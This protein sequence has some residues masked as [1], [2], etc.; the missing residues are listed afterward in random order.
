MTPETIGGYNYEY[1]AMIAQYTGWTYH[2]TFG[3]WADLETKLANHEIDL[4][5]DVGKTTERLSRYNF[6]DYPNISSQMY[7]VTRDNDTRYYYDDFSA[8]NGMKIGG[9]IS[10]FREGLLSKKATNNSFQ[11]TYQCYSSDDTALAALDRG[12]ID[13]VTLINTAKSQDYRI[14]SEWEPNP[15]YF[16]VS[17]TKSEILDELNRSLNAIQ[18]SDPSLQSR[19]YEKYFEDSSKGRNV[20]L[21][22]DEAN[23]LAKK[24]SVTIAVTSGEKPIAYEKDGVLQGI[25]PDYFSLLQTKMPLKFN[26]KVYGTFQEMFTLFMA[27]KSELCAQVPDDFSYGVTL[28]ARLANPYM[29]LTYGFVSKPDL[30]GNAKKIAYRVGKKYLK[31]RLEKLGYEAISYV[32][33]E[34]CISAVI[35]GEVDAAAMGTL[36]YEQV[37]YHAKYRSLSYFTKPELDYSVCIGVT[38][39]EDPLL[40]SALQKAV[41]AIPASALTSLIAADSIVTPQ[42]TIS[43]YMANNGMTLFALIASLLIVALLVTFLIRGHRLNKKSDLGLRKSG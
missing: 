41:G 35:S 30:G 38:T 28:N 17:N 24:E 37:S 7:L 13:A 40:F 12:D 42:Y 22:K 27:G 3:D 43:D 36:A 16:T 6:S 1:L 20:A 29:S 39:N 19:L 34:A 9:I 21:T 4:L 8:F 33:D 31:G 2:Y 32:D 26:Y 11:Y 25:L 14:I 23:Y 10:D 18:S 5:G 15:F